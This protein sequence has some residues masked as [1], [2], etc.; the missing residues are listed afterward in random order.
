[1]SMQVPTNDQPESVSARS[2]KQKTTA[3][4]NLLKIKINQFDLRLDLIWPQVQSR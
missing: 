4:C 2:R 3:K 1:M